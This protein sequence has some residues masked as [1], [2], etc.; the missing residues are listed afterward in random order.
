MASKKEL[1]EGIAKLLKLKGQCYMNLIDD[2]DISD[3]TLKQIN[4]LKAMNSSCGVTTSQLA[5]ELDLS[6]PTVTEMVKKFKKMDCVYKQS[7]PADGRVY[8]L[9]LTEKGEKIANVESMSMEF[10]AGKLIGTL[11]EEDIE[12]LVSILNKIG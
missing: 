3:M 10:L 11:S 12:T 5:D 2:L 8:Y 6:K 7:C 9:K 1:S 4:Y